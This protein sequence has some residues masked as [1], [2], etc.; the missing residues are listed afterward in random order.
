ASFQ[1]VQAMIADIS[2]HLYISRLLAYS[3]ARKLEKGERVTLGASFTKLFASEASVKSTLDAIQILGGYGYTREYGVERL[4]R[5]AKLVE[6][7]GGTS[8]IQRLI[9]AREVYKQAG[10][11]I[12]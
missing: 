5:D 1:L 7:G 11:E 10:L 3:A 12:H 2:M 6:I 9:I 4:M 8:Q